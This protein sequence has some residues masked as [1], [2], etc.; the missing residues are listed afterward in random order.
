MLKRFLARRFFR[1]PPV[2]ETWE[3]MMTFTSDSG[4]KQG[5]QFVFYCRKQ[6]KGNTLA[7]CKEIL[8]LLLC[9]YTETFTQSRCSLFSQSYFLQKRQ[10]TLSS[11]FNLNNTVFLSRSFWLIVAPRKFDVLKT[12]F[13]R[14]NRSFEDKYASSKKVVDVHS[15]QP[16]CGLGGLGVYGLGAQPMTSPIVITLGSSILMRCLHAY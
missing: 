3:V 10:K 6:F 7:D 15:T 1:Y 5:R 8:I 14:E 9:N 12:I 4:I 11:C 13:L 2:M 16:D